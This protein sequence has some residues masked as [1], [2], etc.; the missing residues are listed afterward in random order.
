MIYAFADPRPVPQLTP[1]IERLSRLLADLERIRDGDHP[2]RTLAI[3]LAD[4]R[5]GNISW[6]DIAR[7]IVLSEPPGV[8]KPANIVRVKRLTRPFGLSTVRN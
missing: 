2:D 8:G 4:Y 6:A 7:G 1:E 3:D 5:V